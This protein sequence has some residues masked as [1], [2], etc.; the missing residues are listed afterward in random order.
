M[1]YSFLGDQLQTS[2]A[3]FPTQFS[4]DFLAPKMAPKRSPKHSK[5]PP[6]VL[7]VTKNINPDENSKPSE[8]ISFYSVLATCATQVS[9]HMPSKSRLE[10]WS[11]T[12]QL[13][14]IVFCRFGVSLEGPGVDPRTNIFIKICS[15]VSTERPS[16]KNTKTHEF[17]NIPFCGDRM[18]PEGFQGGHPNHKFFHFF[19]RA[20][21]GGPW[22]AQGHQKHSP[23][24]Q[25]STPTASK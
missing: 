13:V 11:P 3:R 21:L 7:K 22:A 24:S 17:Q 5:R 8:T 9:I 10:T 4:I 14:S 12:H 15:S 18:P 19:L 2:R 16:S 20:S 23:R 25:K 1:F 6:K